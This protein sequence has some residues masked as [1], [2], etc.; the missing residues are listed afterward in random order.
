MWLA[1][2][3][4]TLAYLFDVTSI[5]QRLL[6]WTRNSVKVKIR[7][8]L[9]C[10]HTANVATNA[11]KKCI[12][13]YQGYRYCILTCEHRL[14]ELPLN[15]S[16]CAVTADSKLRWPCSKKSVFPWCLPT[17]PMGLG[18]GLAPGEG[19]ESMYPGTRTDSCSALQWQIC[20]ILPVEESW[21]EY[22]RMCPIHYCNQDSESW[23]YWSCD[24]CLVFTRFLS[25]TMWCLHAHF[26]L[27]ANNEWL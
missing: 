6:P 11:F 3:K 19:Q 15:L 12:W 7:F 2:F 1:F 16:F 14:W 26:T 22:Q 13:K 5:G 23:T 18:F 8:H 9:K 4:T 24:Y 25:N 10:K 20:A 27:S 17:P 21:A